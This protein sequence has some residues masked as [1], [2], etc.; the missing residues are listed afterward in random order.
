MT[1]LGLG[2]LQPVFILWC[3]RFSTRTVYK[4]KTAAQQ[5]IFSPGNQGL[6][7]DKT[8][9]RQVLWLLDLNVAITCSQQHKHSIWHTIWCIQCEYKTE[10]QG[11]SK[12]IVHLA[13]HFNPFLQTFPGGIFWAGRHFLAPFLSEIQEPLT[14]CHLNKLAKSYRPSKLPYIV[15]CTFPSG[16][17]LHKLVL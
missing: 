8:S 13:R 11:V 3:S 10:L 4:H 17:R 9:C 2:L 7:M 1:W 5:R 14:F 16:Q 12:K 6:M 15:L